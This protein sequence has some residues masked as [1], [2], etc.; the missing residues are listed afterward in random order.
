MDKQT[1][2]LAE[3]FMRSKN[4]QRTSIG[5]MSS[6]LLEF[7]KTLDNA[8]LIPTPAQVTDTRVWVEVPISIKPEDEGEYWVN[9]MDKMGRDF[10]SVSVFE[11]G[12]WQP[13]LNFG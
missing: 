11:K 5:N 4:I 12:R 6:V 8:E 7:A 1:K 2:E 13:K 3:A 9:M 10:C